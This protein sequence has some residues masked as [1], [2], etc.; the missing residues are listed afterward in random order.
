MK[1]KFF[2]L[3]CVLTAEM[4]FATNGSNLTGV[5]PAS[6]GMGGIGVGMPVGATD[7]TFRNPAWMP[8]Y[9]DFNMS[10]DGILFLPTVKART[11]LTPMGPMNPPAFEKSGVDRSVIPGISVVDQYDERLWLGIAAYGVSGFGVDYRNKDQR[12]ANM[13]TNFQFLRIMP[14]MAY[15]VNDAFSIGGAVH[16]AY[17]SLDMGA[18]LCRPSTPPTCW[19][20]GGG[21]SQTFGAGFQLGFA[22]NSEDRVFAGF[23]YQS[24]VSMTYKKVFDS[25]GNG[26]FEDFKLHQPQEVAFG[27]GVK[28]LENFKLGTDL[29][30][31]N[32]ENAKGYENFQ[33][34]DQWVIAVGGE[35]K[36][37]ENIELRAGWNYGKSPIRDGARNPATTRNI[38][39]FTA[40]FNDLQIAYFNLVGF[41]AITEQHL[42]FGIGYKATENFGLD[43]SYKH[44]FNKK[45]RATDTLGIG[46]ITEAQNAQNAF[47]IGLNWNF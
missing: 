37:A 42:T 25:D 11:N 17:G 2:L 21:Q 40:P 22:F 26:A 24:P 45:V 47:S 43:I 18:N 14:S 16:I 3:I 41:P 31:I 20:A 6:R 36:P 10:F 33:W 38:P 1:K 23:T 29:R 9:K 44:A 30:W 34:K 39:N 28:P 19:N 15:K 35:Y 7:T 46:F 8:Y 12:L 5:S 13:H 32:W 27:F 4:V